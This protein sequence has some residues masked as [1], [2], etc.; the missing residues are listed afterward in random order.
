MLFAACAAS[1]LATTVYYIED[2]DSLRFALSVYDGYDVAAMQPHFPGYPVF[3]AAAKLGYSLTGSFAAAFS[4]IGGVATFGVALALQRLAGEKLNGTEGW[5]LAALAIFGPLFWLMSNRYMPDM[6]GLALALGVFWFLTAPGRS[7][8]AGFALAG[9]LAGLRLSYMPFALVPM[10]AALL[11]RRNRMRRLG[12]FA[13]GVLVWLIPMTLDAGFQNL[14]ASAGRQTAGHFAEF[15]GTVY[16]ESGLGV[17]FLRLFEAIWADGLGAWW[18]DRHPL[19]MVTGAGV[20]VLVAA[21]APAFAD[22]IRRDPAWRLHLAA[23]ATYGLWA[24]CFQNVLH[25]SRHALPLLPLLL[26]AVG[27]GLF[28]LIRARSP[29]ARAAAIVFLAAYV[30]TG[31]V[32]A[33]QHRQPTAIAQAKTCIEASLTGEDTV[34]SIPLVHFYLSAQGV[35]AQYATPEDLTAHRAEQ[36]R[37]GRVFVVGDFPLSPPGRLAASGALYHNPYVNRMWSEVPMRVYDTG[38]ARADPAPVPCL[39]QE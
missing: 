39:D 29:F 35:A 32:L 19:T 34:A 18:L 3:W 12:I 36:E 7:R 4:L 24:L 38:P 30:A 17:R 27:F 11:P 9:L 26:M 14:L 15:G 28:R 2:P 25:K 20:L 16:T 8:E 21:G 33:M 6:A 5:A 22:R 31:V 10:C 1:R 37:P 13:A 23:W